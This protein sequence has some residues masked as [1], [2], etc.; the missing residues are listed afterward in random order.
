MAAKARR[1]VA[2]DATA[3]PT[4]GQNVPRPLDACTDARKRQVISS[5]DIYISCYTQSEVYLACSHI[6]F[7]SRCV[8][9]LV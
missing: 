4:G 8:F 5:S 6:I 3:R 7:E 1:K 2:D 9:L